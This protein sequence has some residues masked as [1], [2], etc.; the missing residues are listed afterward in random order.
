MKLFDYQRDPI[1]LMIEDA[2]IVLTPPIVAL[3][4][5]LLLE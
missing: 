1:S 2:I 5:I 3:I 4:G